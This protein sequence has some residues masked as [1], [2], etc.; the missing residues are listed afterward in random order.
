[1]N[2][3]EG[4]SIDILAPVVKSRK[5]EFESLFKDLHSQGFF[6]FNLQNQC[7]DKGLS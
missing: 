2:F 7:F 1:M 4:S 6:S 5:G 3:G